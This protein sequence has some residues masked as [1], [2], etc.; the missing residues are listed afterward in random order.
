MLVREALVRSTTST[1]VAR[2]R[3]TPPA[4]LVVRPVLTPLSSL[5]GISD[6]L[7]SFSYPHFAFSYPHFT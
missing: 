7:V 3:L 4:V 5:V 6:A 1:P 2:Q